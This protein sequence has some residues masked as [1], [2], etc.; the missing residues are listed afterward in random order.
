M[1]KLD[2]EHETKQTADFEKLLNG[3]KKVLIICQHGVRSLR[4]TE[5][6]INQGFNNV[7]SVRGGVAEYFGID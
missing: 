1:P 5:Q 3:N 6:L 7:V 4:L 2:F